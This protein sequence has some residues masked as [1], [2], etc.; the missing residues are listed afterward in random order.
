MEI[1]LNIL[2]LI[3]TFILTEFSAWANHKYIMHGSMWHFHADHHKK[4][5]NSWFERNDIFFFMYA[6]PSWLLIMFGIMNGFA[7]FTWVGF[8]IAL[9]GFAYF[10]VHDIIIHQRFKILTKSTN[11]YVLALRRAH[12]M[13]HKH[14][15]KE[16][17][18]SFGM[19]IIKKKYFAE[20]RKLKAANIK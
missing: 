6:I 4:D 17:G 11:L 10:F 9:Y 7:W 3:V 2:I 1:I 16:D 15:G 20:A 8:G 18:E 13:H 14:I 5:H 19:L 12:K